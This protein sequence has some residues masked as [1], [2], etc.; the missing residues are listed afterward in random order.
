MSIPE[1]RVGI[2]V[3]RNGQLATADAAVRGLIEASTKAKRRIIQPFE[4]S[5]VQTQ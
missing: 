4:K 3:N 1:S 5:L 2:S